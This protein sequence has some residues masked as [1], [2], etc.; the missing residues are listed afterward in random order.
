MNYKELLVVKNRLEQLACK[1]NKLIHSEDLH[2][3]G[4]QINAETAA[5]YLNKIHNKKLTTE[6]FEDIKQNKLAV[7]FIYGGPRNPEGSIDAELARY[8]AIYLRDSDNFPTACIHVQG[9]KKEERDK[10]KDEL[11]Q[12]DKL[13]ERLA[14]HSEESFNSDE[15]LFEAHP[16]LE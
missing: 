7:G 13:Y 14:I 1:D 8:T 11:N 3:I 5:D 4:I 12:I 6:E 15:D 10:F 16:N 2:D 9:G